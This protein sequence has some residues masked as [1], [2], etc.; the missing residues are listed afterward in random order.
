MWYGLSRKFELLVWW[1]R[2]F[3]F[4]LHQLALINMFMC[5]TSAIY[6]PNLLVLY[7]NLALWSKRWPLSGTVQWVLSS[8][9]LTYHLQFHR[10]D[11]FLWS[12]RFLLMDATLCSE[13]RWTVKV[14]QAAKVQGCQINRKGE[15]DETENNPFGVGRSECQHSFSMLASLEQVGAEMTMWPSTL[16][17]WDVGQFH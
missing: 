1:V 4:V 2:F 15:G 9:S 17:R 3:T 8:I 10:Y 12:L 5:Y 13:L 7:D 6:G 11:F 14:R 16:D